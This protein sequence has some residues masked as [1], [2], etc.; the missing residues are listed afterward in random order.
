MKTPRHILPLIVVAQFMS[1]SLWF[2]SNAV[3]V[4]LIQAYAIDE[5]ALGALTSF[6]QFGFMVGTL[7]FAVLAIAD[8]FSPSKVFAFSGFLGAFCTIGLLLPQND[9]SRLLL[10]R[11]LTGFFLAGIYPVGMKIAADYFSINLNKSLGFLVGALVLGT[12]LPHLL[13]DIMN[14][15]NWRYVIYSV[16]SLAVLGSLI[17]LL[18]VPDGPYRKAGSNIK[19]NAFFK[20]FENQQFRAAAF[21]YFGHMWELYTFWAFIPVILLKYQETHSI[22]SFAFPLYSFLII[23]AGSLGCVLAGVASQKFGEKKIA[24]IALSLSAICCLILP[25]LFQSQQFFVFFSFMLL[26]GIAVVADSPLFSTLI[27]KSAKPELKGTALTIVNCIGYAIT[28]LSISILNSLIQAI[29]SS[30]VYMLLAI[31]PILGLWS[32]RKYRVQ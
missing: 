32:F 2:A 16:S 19:L 4:D 6:V 24:N 28:I 26:W 25:F 15:L 27:A 21:G 20:V 17:I 22:T 29:D 23:A 1:T 12:A 30:A 8:R 10:F 18:F 31:G 11:F 5:A 14:G 13:K 9:L 7:T 3:M